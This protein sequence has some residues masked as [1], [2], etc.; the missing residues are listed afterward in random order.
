M[1]LEDELAKHGVLLYSLVA[2][3]HFLRLLTMHW[4]Q[5]QQQQQVEQLVVP[6]KL[7]YL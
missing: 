4:Y 1:E 2:K 7:F 5:K 6:T 3:R